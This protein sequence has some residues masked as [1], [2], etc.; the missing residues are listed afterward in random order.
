MLCHGNTSFQ[1]CH[2]NVV[3]AGNTHFLGQCGI[4][5]LPRSM[6]KAIDALDPA[7]MVIEED[8]SKYLDENFMNN[9]FSRIHSDSNGNEVPLQ[10]LVDAMTYQYE[11]KQTEAIDRSKILPFVQLNQSFSIRNTKKTLKPQKVSS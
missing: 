9:I 6:G 10:L 1:N 8:G 4:D 2:A 11:H 3:V 7:M 5:W